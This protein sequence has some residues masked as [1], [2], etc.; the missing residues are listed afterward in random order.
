MKFDTFSFMQSPT[1]KP[2]KEVYD[3]TVEEVVYADELGFSREDG[4]AA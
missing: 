2:F 3:E 4:A 1:G